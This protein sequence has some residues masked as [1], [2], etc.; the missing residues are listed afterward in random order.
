MCS[1]RNPIVFTKED[2]SRTLKLIKSKRCF[3][4][5]GL[6]LKVA[7]DFCEMHADH[8]IELFNHYCAVGIPA[9]WKMARIIPLFK[10]GDR[11]SEK[12]YRPI[13]N[14]VSL[15]KIFEKMVLD[16]LDKETSNM[17][18]LSQHGFRNNHSTLTATLEM[19]SFIAESLDNGKNVIVYSID[20]SAA[21]DMLREDLLTNLIKGS[22]TEGL[23]YT[24]RDFLTNRSILVDINGV[25]SEPKPLNL[26]CVQGSS[27]GPRL[28]TIYGGKISEKINADHYTSF[29]DDSYVVATGSNLDEAK[30]KIRDISRRHVDYLKSLGLVVNESKT[31]AV[32]FSKR[33]LVETDI[34]I[35]GTTIKTRKQ[36]KVLGVLF[37]NNLTWE[38]HIRATLNKCKSK[39]GVLKKL[40]KR[41]T[42]D[43]FLQ[44]V[45]AQYYSLLY[46]CAPVWLNES[47]PAKLRNLINSAHYRPLRIARYDY[48]HRLSKSEL[49]KSCERA[50]PMEWVRYLLASQVIKIVTNREPFYLYNDIIKNIYTTRRKPLIGN[51]FDNSKG[52]IG[53][54]KLGN[55]LKFMAKINWDWIDTAMTKDRLRIRLK[56][57]YFGYRT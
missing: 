39:L 57:T 43:Q 23:L 47:T 6:P 44:I 45:T 4:V 35:N 36:M 52:K 3:G 17:L 32:V 14:L 22:V 53:K 15:S 42:K 50:T 48:G 18:G 56:D 11:L 40:R 13:A 31:E 27:L 1:P 7:K 34:N 28:F 21:F 24:V 20:L 46:Y 26:G 10:N 5:D 41:F 29:A 55:R 16:R 8:V 38:P 33:G 9:K 49:S 30:D 25:Q 19:Q 54:Q 51:F 37:D 2:L 12:N